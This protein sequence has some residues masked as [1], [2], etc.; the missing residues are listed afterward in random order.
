[1]KDYIVTCDKARAI[2]E[3]ADFDRGTFDRFELLRFIDQQEA[4]REENAKLRA[5]CEAAIGVMRDINLQG[6]Y[7][8]AWDQLCEALEVRL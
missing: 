3:D 2:V 5:A 6:A 4:L 7:Y 1:M 8:I